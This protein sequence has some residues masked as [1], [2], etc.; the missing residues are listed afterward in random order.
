MRLRQSALAGSGCETRQYG[1]ASPCSARAASGSLAQ[2]RSLQHSSAT[3]RRLRASAL[4]S[5]IQPQRCVDVSAFDVHRTTDPVHQRRAGSILRPRTGLPHPLPRRIGGDCDRPPAR[6]PTF[7]LRG[8]PRLRVFALR[9]Q[10]SGMSD[11]AERATP[12]AEP[13]RYRY[14]EE[15]TAEQREQLKRSRVV[16]AEAYLRWLETGEG[17]EPCG[18]FSG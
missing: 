18:D 13:P 11:P 10:T 5:P 7:W 17:P 4:P 16:D 14:P 8:V 12:A 6:D 2:R 15:L 1:L 3:V 9:C